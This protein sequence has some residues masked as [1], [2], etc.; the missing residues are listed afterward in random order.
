MCFCDPNNP[1][2]Y[3]GAPECFDPQDP[4]GLDAE[5]LVKQCPHTTVTI[6]HRMHTL[7]DNPNRVLEIRLICKNPECRSAFFFNNLPQNPGNEIDLSEPA[8]TDITGRIGRF[9]V[10]PEGGI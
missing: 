1:S 8:T 7:P 6:Q 5:I 3:C 10:R 9:I 2:R 4:L